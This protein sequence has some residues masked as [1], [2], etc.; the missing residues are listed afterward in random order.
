[1]EWYN[2]LS[3]VFGGTSLLGVIGAIVYFKPRLKIEN[4][5]ADDKDVQV[6]QSSIT[7]L[8]DVNEQLKEAHKDMAEMR[9]SISNQDLSILKLKRRITIL[10][11][12]AERQT[13]LKKYAESHL[14]TVMNCDFRE[15]PFGT[16]KTSSDSSELQT[17]IEE[18]RKDEQNDIS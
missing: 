7:T 4:L 11:D 3:L 6:S 5:N 15:P 10:I 17:L 8:K 13:G 18:L 14:C 16:Y 9:K 12:I 1:M 2:I